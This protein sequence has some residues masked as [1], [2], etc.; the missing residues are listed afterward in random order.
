MNLKILI[1]SSFLLLL[2]LNIIVVSCQSKSTK[3]T[4]GAELYETYCTRCHGDDGK[5]GYKGA[6]DLT[7]ADLDLEYTIEQIKYGEG[8]MPAF[9]KKISEE[10]IKLLA[11]YTMSKFGTETEVIK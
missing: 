4:T 11:E 8:Q 7:V 5:K 10:E 9:F 6:E 3:P 2:V 1:P